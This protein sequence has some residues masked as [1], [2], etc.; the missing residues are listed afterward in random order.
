MLNNI[1][2]VRDS[3]IIGTDRPHAVLI[4]EPGANQ[5]QLVQRANA[6]LEDHQK[7]RSS[8]LW[9][10]DQFPRTE[11]TG[12]LKRMEIAKGT[13]PPQRSAKVDLSLPLD[14]L[15]S[16]ERVERMVAL[17]VDESQMAAT[18]E[19]VLPP[20]ADFDFPDWNRGFAARAL[21][22]VF[23]PGFLLPLLRVFAWIRRRGLENLRDVTPP[24]IFASNHQS[25]MDVPAI[26]AALPA[27]FRY[28]VAPAMRKEF[29][30]AHYH[31]ERYGL[32]A[33]FINSL[34]YY[35]AALVFNGFPIPQREAGT[36][37]TLRYMGEISSQGWCIL[38]FP[39][40]KMTDAGE[41][42]AF[43]PGV[44]M[45]ASRLELPV[46]PVRIHGLH[47][48]LHKT[49]RLARPGCV[50]IAFGKPLKLSGGDYIA[51]TRKVEEA[52]K[53]L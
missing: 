32:R 21:R 49:W 18:A 31:P 26:L 25:Y 46:V 52:V 1:P 38:I 13:P 42:S 7:I 17:N 28:C 15:T 34:N 23:L 43:H 45:I 41:I 50:E 12:K 48:V 51:N 24:V 19:A 16:L 6:Q 37:E 27:R 30:E 33:R 9:P 4:L 10:Y 29:F 39:E 47:Q 14:Q 40:G 36:L 44:G 8:S 2:G 3:A 5:E 35:L 11:G 20:P 22:R 53:Q